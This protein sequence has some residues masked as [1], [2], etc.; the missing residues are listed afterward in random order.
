MSIIQRINQEN[1]SVWIQMGKLCEQMN[2]VDKALLAYEHVL[3]FNHFNIQAL[4]QIA[5]IYR[6]KDQFQK[7]VE[8]YQKALAVESSNYEVWCALGHCFLMMDDLNKAYTAYHQALYN[9]KLNNNMKVNLHFFL[10]TLKS[11]IH[12]CG[13][14]LEFYMRDM[15]H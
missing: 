8:Y 15:V 5:S 2:D 4:S 3:K 12:T 6:S 11:K 9:A 14:E 1:E 7:A 13:M 10:K